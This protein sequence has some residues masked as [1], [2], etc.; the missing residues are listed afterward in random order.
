MRRSAGDR[1]RALGAAPPR[2]AADGKRARSLDRALVEA[3][4][5]NG[6]GLIAEVKRRSPS[7]GSL[8][9]DLDPAQLAALYVEAGACAV[10]ILTEPT[11]F[12]GT[13]GDLERAAAAVPVPV[14]RKDFLL[15]PAQ[16]HESRAAGADAVLLIVRLLEPPRLRELLAC[17]EEA[18]LEA[19]VEIHAPAELAVALSE[20]ARIIGVNNRDLATLRTDA[21]HSLE[22]ARQA[23]ETGMAW[24]ALAVSESGIR[25]RA[26]V[27]TLVRA[28]YHGIL[29]GE[30]LLRARDPARTLRELLGTA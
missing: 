4:G 3:A 15:E 29:V 6:C 18:G 25:T 30:T 13:L 19:L 17:A 10:S 12:G 8:K 5:A 24:P 23:R 9:E 28:G 26:Q 11:R 14:L 20:G 21:T 7:A 22:V 1:A 16:I 27:E 2:P